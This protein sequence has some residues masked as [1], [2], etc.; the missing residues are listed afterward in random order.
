MTGRPRGWKPWNPH[1]ATR[2]LLDQ[3]QE[4]L[5]ETRPQV[6]ALTVRQLFYLMVV[7]HGFEK[8]EKA[9]ARLGNYLDRGRRSRRIPMSAIREE[10]HRRETPVGWESPD[11]LVDQW[12][13]H[14]ANFRFNRQAGQP[15]F[16]VV[17]CEA[18]GMVGQLADAV[19]DFGVPV[20]SSGGFDSITLKHNFAEEVRARFDHGGNVGTRILHVGDRDPSGEHIHSSLFN[21]VN[22]FADGAVEMTRLAVT[23][24]Q[25]EDMN[26]PTAPPKSTD[27]RSFS[28]LTTQAEAIPPADLRRIVRLAVRSR[29][30]HDIFNRLRADELDVRAELVDLL[31]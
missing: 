20:L 16:I 15:E 24:R 10:S 23:E 9:Y 6:G 26:L 11:E 22:A 18:Q 30:D 28:G 13:H 3:I 17:W 27:K 1:L 29:I 19:R 2:L 14:A 4:I 12:H 7:R 31:G 21:D 25:V 5:D 8:T